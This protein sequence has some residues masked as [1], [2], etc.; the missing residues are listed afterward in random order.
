VREHFSRAIVGRVERLAL[1]SEL[2]ERV[3]YARLLQAAIEAGLVPT[4]CEVSAA[5]AIVVGPS[6]ANVLAA[7]LVAS[8][9]AG[10]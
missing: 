8:E 7:S 4:E 2:A 6:T 1:M 5:G 9:I 3:T 10:E